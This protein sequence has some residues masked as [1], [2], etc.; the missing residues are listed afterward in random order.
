MTTSLTSAKLLSRR[1]RKNSLGGRTGTA[2]LTPPDSGTNLSNRRVLDLGARFS[3]SGKD[4]NWFWNGG[5]IFFNWISKAIDFI[6]F[7][8]AT[9]WS[10][11]ISAIEQIKAFN[12][13]ETDENLEKQFKTA[14][15]QVASLWGGVFGNLAGGLLAVAV[16]A[17]VGLIVPVIG[18]A[19]LAKTIAAQVAKDR[20]EEWLG[21][22]RNAIVTT[23]AIYAQQ[24]PVRLYIG[25]RRF[26]K[27]APKELLRKIYSEETVNFIKNEWGTQGAP[28]LS[29]NSKM[30]EAVESIQDPRLQ[31]FVEEFLEEAWD[32]FVE[33]GYVAA[34]TIDDFWQQQKEQKEKIFGDNK[35]VIIQPDVNNDSETIVLQNI[36]KQLAMPTIQQTINNARLLQ[37]RDVGTVVAQSLEEKVLASPQSLRLIIT[38][39]SVP[40]PPW[41]ARSGEQKFI[42]VQVSIP[43]VKRTKL[44]WETIKL[45]CGL[46]G[47]Q[48]GR[49]KAIAKLDNG[50]EMSLYGATEQEAIKQL[51]KF[52][53][54]T[55]ANLIGMTVSEEQ[56]KGQRLVNQKLYKTPIRIYPAFF[57]I[58]NREPLLEQTEQGRASLKGNFRDRRIKINL[59]TSTKPNH[60][61]QVIKDIL[62]YGA[63]KSK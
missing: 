31:A 41:R 15:I 24:V 19:L 1:I 25:Y 18:G 30:N 62:A 12:W 45:T 40:S 6:G 28:R 43:N 57:I 55:D 59:W 50:R 27:N 2:I 44:D 3:K 21:M 5:K 29:F 34:Q 22:L 42:K 54:L 23:V 17:G 16:G 35:T 60:T 32:S 37:N 13:N 8:A 56:K 10:W 63:P 26:L 14:E 51:E 9:I 53:L 48:W 39:T 49:F 7:S 47:Y 20:L 38:L 58:I 61:D 33:G 52:L 4:T 46:N 36:P 11:C